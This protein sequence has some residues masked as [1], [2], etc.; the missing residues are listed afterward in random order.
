LLYDNLG[1]LPADRIT[2]VLEACFS[3]LSPAGAVLGKASPV[4]FDVKAPQI[5]PRLTVIAAGAAN[6]VASWEPDDSHGLF[7]RHFLEGMA[8]KADADRDGKVSLDEIDRYLKDTL[9]YFARRHYGR[10]QQAQIIQGGAR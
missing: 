9:T 10:D 7:T 8:G 4:Y 1:K 6:Q 3:G 5:P 2:V